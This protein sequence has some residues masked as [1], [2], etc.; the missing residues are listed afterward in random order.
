MIEDRV[1]RAPAEC[2][3][4]GALCASRL[5]APAVHAAQEVTCAH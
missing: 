5:A 2:F 3:G 4:I 1:K